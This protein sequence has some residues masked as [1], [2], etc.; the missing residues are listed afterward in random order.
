MSRTKIPKTVQRV[1]EQLGAG[2][3]LCRQRTPESGDIFYFYEPSG[4]T[5]GP[6]TA[7]KAIELGLVVP[8]GDALF[9]DSD[10]QTWVAG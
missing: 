8:N 4:K 7:Q 10:S 5:C 2:Q 9:S 3:K 6:R 1:L